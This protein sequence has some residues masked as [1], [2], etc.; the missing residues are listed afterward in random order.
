MEKCEFC[1][2]EK[3]DSYG[4]KYTVREIHGME[5]KE[6]GVM[7]IALHAM[8]S[9]VVMF[10][11][12]PGSADTPMYWICSDC[13]S[14]CLSAK[15]TGTKQTLSRPQKQTGSYT[16]D[17]CSIEMASKSSGNTYRDEYVCT[18]PGYWKIVADKIE[19]GEDAYGHCL[20]MRLQDKTGFTVCKQCAEMITERDQQLKELGLEKLKSSGATTRDQI[21]LISGVVWEQKMGTWPSFLDGSYK[22]IRDKLT[23]NPHPQHGDN[24]KVDY[25]EVQD[26][27]DRDSLAYKA[28]KLWV[29]ITQKLRG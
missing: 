9:S 22:Q 15:S 12:P 18:C 11:N 24:I 10:D 29:K 19:G 1:N 17:V 14:K 8:A 2:V 26:V 27:I 4:K 21:A 25:E 28:G 5:V 16:C 20:Q 7:A 6:A 23:T 13:T 3:D